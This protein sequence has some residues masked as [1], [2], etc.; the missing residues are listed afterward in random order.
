M[1]N[2]R[3]KSFFNDHSMY[4]I[5]VREYHKG[6]EMLKGNIVKTTI[7]LE[8]IK[9]V[10]LLPKSKNVAKIAHHD[11][12]MQAY[13]NRL[14]YIVSNTDNKFCRRMIQAVNNKEFANKI[15]YLE[16]QDKDRLYSVD[17][18]TPNLVDAFCPVSTKILIAELIIRNQ[19]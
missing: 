12:Q 16:N 18:N 8:N 4:G 15:V 1:T 5:A 9:K 7:N 13:R 11:F 19:L 10:K 6:S 3:I 17:F 14:A 2:I